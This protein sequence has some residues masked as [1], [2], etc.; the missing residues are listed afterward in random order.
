MM[1]NETNFN[2]YFMIHFVLSC[3]VY[4]FEHESKFWICTTL[5]IKSKEYGKFVVIINLVA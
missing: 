3:M 1:S 4:Y 5:Q 2:M